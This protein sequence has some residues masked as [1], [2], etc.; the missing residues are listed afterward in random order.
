MGSCGRMSS[1][2]RRD[3]GGS[4]IGSG[5]ETTRFPTNQPEGIIAGFGGFLGRKGDGHPGP[6]AIWEGIQKVSAFAF[7]IV[8]AKQA[9]IPSG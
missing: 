5:F 6:K 9:F 1:W 2:R 8:A 4:S 3:W 7:G